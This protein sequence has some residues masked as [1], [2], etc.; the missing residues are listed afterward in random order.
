MTITVPLDPCNPAHA[1]GC[2]GLLELA[3]ALW[4]EAVPTGHFYG[5]DFLIEHAP[6]GLG[7]L[8][9]MVKRLTFAPISDAAAGPVE[10][11]DPESGFRMRLD[12]WEPVDGRR[13]VKTFAGQQRAVGILTDLKS[14]LAHLACDERLPFHMGMPLTGRFGFDPAATWTAQ[15]AGWSL[16]KQGVGPVGSALAELL[17]A[18][19][20]HTARPGGGA[21]ITYTLWRPSLPTVAARLAIVAA[22]GRRFA[23]TP[24][25]R[26][27]QGRYKDFTMATEVS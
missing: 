26:D 13:A 4:P 3:D 19:G 12:P 22:A 5:E 11:V 10:A 27:P 23:F 14:S 15:S 25:N 17:A 21:E 7:D 18:I 8:L 24:R 6:G 1:F 16:D 9:A 2:L 20:L